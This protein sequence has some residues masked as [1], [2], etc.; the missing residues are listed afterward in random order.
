MR[1]PGRPQEA[2]HHRAP[3]RDG[4][5]LPYAQRMR[6]VALRLNCNTLLPINSA[7][8]VPINAAQN[9]NNWDLRGDDIDVERD[10][11][12]DHAVEQVEAPPC[13][14]CY[15]EIGPCYNVEAGPHV[16]YEAKFRFWV[17]NPPKPSGSQIWV[18]QHI[19]K[20]IVWI[21]RH[22][23]EFRFKQVVNEAFPLWYNHT[24]WDEHCEANV[25][26]DFC[27]FRIGV[28][29]SQYLIRFV[30]DPGTEHQITWR[31]SFHEEDSSGK[32]IGREQPMSVMSISSEASGGDFRDDP[33]VNRVG[34]Y[35]GTNNY[36]VKVDHCNLV[37]AYDL[38][39]RT[40]QGQGQGVTDEAVWVM[41]N[42]VLSPRVPGGQY[43]GPRPPVRDWRV[44]VDPP[45]PEGSEESGIPDP[46]DV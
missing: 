34:R 18:G 45:P 44:P 39:Y 14:K 40:V 15:P 5:S 8:A 1:S 38:A 46:P 12:H 7:S 23:T 33:N 35:Y 41:F 2:K 32:Q 30:K 37:W 36:K 4:V 6:P 21:D 16:A 42:E 27:A 26:P 9:G 17:D 28:K 43:R 20:D 31:A 24:D 13:N 11:I 29:S 10:F 22:R 19:E 3:S 25:F